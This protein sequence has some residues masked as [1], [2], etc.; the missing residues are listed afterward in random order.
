MPRADDL[1]VNLRGLCERQAVEIRDEDFHPDSQQLTQMLHKDLQG[2]GRGPFKSRS[3]RFAAPMLAGVGV[4]VI[5]LAAIL[6]LNRAKEPG[7]AGK[8]TALVKYD[9]GDSYKTFFDFEVDGPEISGMAGYGAD[10]AGNGRAILNGKIAGDQ[11]SFM[12][13]SQVTMDFSQP[14]AEERHYYKGKVEG[15]AI[16]FTLTTEGPI[17][18]NPIQFSAQRLKPDPPRH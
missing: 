6:F 5:I 14:S 4:I 7:V 13:K 8:W 18:H 10:R 15:G 2:I 1:P 9:W 3:T 17:Q 12:T 16:R 11:I